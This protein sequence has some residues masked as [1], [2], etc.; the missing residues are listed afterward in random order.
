MYVPYEM[1]KN[2][3]VALEILFD[4]C[5]SL[6]QHNMETM[7]DIHVCVMQIFQKNLSEIPTESSSS[8]LDPY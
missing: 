7:A 2:S 3:K 6:L 5:L 1:G 4:L 8:I